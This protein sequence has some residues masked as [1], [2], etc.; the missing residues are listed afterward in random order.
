MSVGN[1]CRYRC[2]FK[3]YNVEYLKENDCFSISQQ[4]KF[5]SIFFSISLIQQAQQILPKSEWITI[6]F[7]ITLL[8]FCRS[9]STF[10]DQLLSLQFPLNFPSTKQTK[11]LS[12]IFFVF[13]FSIFL[14]FTLFSLTFLQ[15]DS[16][17]TYEVK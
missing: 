1:I 6:G 7:T 14:L 12:F 2:T 13:L 11:H 4:K 16:L 15:P 5:F 9:S 17:G 3:Y 10:T 8:D